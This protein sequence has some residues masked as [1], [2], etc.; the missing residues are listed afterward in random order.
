MI[1][2]N[3][4]KFKYNNGLFQVLSLELRRTTFGVPKMSK[5]HYKL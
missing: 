2:E 5:Y 4:I 1:L 3:K